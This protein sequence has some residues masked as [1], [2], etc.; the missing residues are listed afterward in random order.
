MRRSTSRR[1]DDEYVCKGGPYA[2]LIRELVESGHYDS[3]AEVV[4]SLLRDQ[5]LLRKPS[6]IGSRPRSGRVSTSPSA[7]N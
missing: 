6:G 2:D 7:A 3:A 4:L 1:N 5:E